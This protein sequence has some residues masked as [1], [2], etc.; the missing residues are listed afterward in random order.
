MEFF[1]DKTN[2]RG[3]IVMSFDDLDLEFEDEEE[4]KKPKAAVIQTNA[5]IQFPPLQQP[6][7]RPQAGAMAE[8]HPVKTV[9]SPSI[10]R[11]EIQKTGNV[12]NL[13]EAR[14]LSKSQ[15]T[16]SRSMSSIVGSSALKTEVSLQVNGDEMEQLRDHARRVEFEAGI[17]VA[18][19]EFKTALL[20]DLMSDIKLVDH[21]IGQL[22]SRMNAKHPDI[23]Q[24]ALMIKKILADFIQKKRK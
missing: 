1:P 8:P 13:N 5:N 6:K 22:L 21:Q 17:K 15:G 18:V 23:R 2:T 9:T 11:P 10:K 12:Q 19:A 4:Q 24:E 16:G 7:A 14:P 3:V 20:T